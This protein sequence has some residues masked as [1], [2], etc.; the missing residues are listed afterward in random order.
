MKT[1]TFD[2]TKW[3]LVPKEP[4]VAM[5]D[6]A[7]AVDPER[8]SVYAAYLTAA[9]EHEPTTISRTK[10]MRDIND[11]MTFG[12]HSLTED[13]EAVL[14]AALQTLIPHIFAPIQPMRG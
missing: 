13:Q 11:L 5:V 14:C 6:A 10:L 1:V 2:E 9:P 4:T 3:Q 8:E 7:C 12:G